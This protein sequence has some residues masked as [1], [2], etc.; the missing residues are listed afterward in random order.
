MR[1]ERIGVNEA[2]PSRDPAFAGSV[3]GVHL[4]IDRDVPVAFM[5]MRF[6]RP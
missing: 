1:L 4:W 5:G 6:G 2:H 3:D